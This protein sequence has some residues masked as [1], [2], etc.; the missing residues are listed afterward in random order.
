MA[1]SNSEM[2]QLNY[3]LIF[4]A[5]VLVSAAVLHITRKLTEKSARPFKFNLPSSFLQVRED[6][7]VR[8]YSNVDRP[9]D[10][11]KSSD[12]LA[13]SELE[14]LNSLRMAGEMRLE[15]KV[16]KAR[17]LYLHA[18]VLAPKHPEVLNKYG[19]YLEHSRR[20]VV[21]ADQMY[22]QVSAR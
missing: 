2:K 6:F 9:V 22:F 4:V 12:D 18:I 8:R 20:D 21:L 16:E 15:G 11:R 1:L 5:G 19:E 10:S 13:A 3:V 14:A 7:Q 17:R